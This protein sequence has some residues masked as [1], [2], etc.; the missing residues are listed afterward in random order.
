[1]TDRPRLVFVS[2]QYLIPADAGGKI[3]TSNILRG[4]RGSR[5]HLTLLSPLPA[6]DIAGDR[7]TLDTLC[8]R[9]TGWPAPRRRQ[10]GRMARLLDL[11]SPLP[12]SVAGDVSAMARELI[13]RELADHADLVVFDYAHSAVLAPAHIAVPSVAFTHN[14]EVEII[15]RHMAHA[16]N[17]L[18]RAVWRNQRA[19]MATFEGDALRRFDTVIAVSERDA[20]QL[21]ERYG[22]PRVEAIPTAVD[23]DFFGFAAPAGTDP[24]ATTIIFT[25]SMDWQANVDGIGFFMDAI[26]PRLAEALPDAKFVAVGRN[27]PPDL[28]RRARGLPWTFT[29]FV[30][31][32]RPHVQQAD[33]YVV[34]LRIGGGTR[35][36]VYEAMAMGCPVVSTGLGVEGLPV[37]PGTHYLAADT[38]ADFAAAILRLAREPA[39]RR[40][41]AEAAR[42]HVEAHFGAAKVAAIF[43]RICL[44]TLER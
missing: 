15:E 33:I 21:R 23:L 12:F 31:D 37:E 1:M 10:A 11:L 29:G 32:I 25:G 20:R 24:A 2:P 17:A 19:K 35:I 26:W 43:E 16:S 14:V 9:F 18:M 13:A 30:D 7:A 6:H 4:M 5:F 27:P 40:R 42:A 38:A 36:K 41:L 3:R 39:L 28:V 22:L 44:A 8:D 34:P